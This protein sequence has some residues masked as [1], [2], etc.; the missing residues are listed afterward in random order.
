MSEPTTPPA[1]PDRRAF[2]GYFASVGLGSTLLPGVLWA[3]VAEGAEVTTASVA[4]A[5]EIAGLTSTRG[6]ARRWSRV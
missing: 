3:K 2:M 4:A 6:S 1:L 5:A